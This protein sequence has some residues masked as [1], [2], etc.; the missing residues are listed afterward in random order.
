MKKITFLKTT[1][2]LA[3][4]TSIGFAQ[5]KE[6][7]FGSAKEYVKKANG[8]EIIR[9][10]STHYETHL[11]QKGK[12][13]TNEVFEG[14]MQKKIEEAKKDATKR[15]QTNVVVTI[16]VVVHVLHSGQP[17]GTG[18]NISDLRVQ[19]QITVLNQDY[20]RMLNTNGYNS[21]TNGADVEV[22]FCL[23]QQTPEGATTNG[24]NR[25]NITSLGV[26]DGYGAAIVESVLKPRTIW[27]P[28]R[29][30]NIWVG[31]FYASAQSDLRGVLGYAQ[32]PTGSG[33]AGLDQEDISSTDGVIIDWH[34]FGSSEIAVGNYINGFNLG[35]TTTHEVGHYLGLRHVN[36]DNE[37]CVVDAIDSHNDYCL[38]TPAQVDLHED[39]NQAYDTCPNSPGLDNVT[40]FMDYSEDAC[41]NKFTNDQ[42]ARIRTVLLN[43]PRRKSL[44]SSA[45]CNTRPANITRDIYLKS[46]L[47]FENCSQYFNA[48]LALKNK[49]TTPVTSAVI[50]YKVGNGAVY[51]YNYTGSIATEATANITIPNIAFTS[52]GLNEV[53]FRVISVNGDTDQNSFN[54]TLVD[55]VYSVINVT[56]PNATLVFYSDGYLEEMSYNVVNTSTNVSIAR[57]TLPNTEVYNGIALTLPNLQNGVCYAVTLT[58]TGNDGLRGLP[59]MLYNGTDFNDQNILHTVYP[60]SRTL[61]F[62]FTKNFILGIDD[63]VLESDKLTIYPNP[64]NSILNIGL[65]ANTDLPKAYTIFNTL[66]QVVKSNSVQ[67]SNDLM[68]DVDHLSNGVYMIK[69]DTLKGSQTI[70]FVKQ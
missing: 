17:V 33:L 3:L 52:I 1:L 65:G 67:S 68:V 58:D 16:P 56:E 9:C 31:D 30:M 61:S 60:M 27:D 40:N 51:T 45:A 21:D 39:C 26:N 37:S 29:Y 44:T 64:T 66:G 34:C 47:E 57:G 20:R 12:L 18:S 28:T 14:W 6:T 62:T 43:S 19:S 41:L 2:I 24:I 48:N 11:Q 53:S 54:S 7:L 50:E 42:K 13:E 32:F 22:E 69:I 55:Y 5:N 70:K 4:T 38:D 8:T 23:V 46:A 63:V 35:R 59:V 49:G 15:R 10:A 36:G 25:V